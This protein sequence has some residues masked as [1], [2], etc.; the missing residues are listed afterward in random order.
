LQAQSTFHKAFTLA[1]KDGILYRSRPVSDG[2]AVSVGRVID[3]STF[4]DDFLIM[5]TDASGGAAWI[6]KC[7]TTDFEE[8]TDVTEVPDG[9]VAVGT[10]SDMT[11]YISVAVVEKFNAAGVSQWVKSYSVSGHSA[12][13]KKISTDASGNLYILGTVAIDGAGDD[14]F[15][16]K[17]DASG[18]ILAQNRFGTPDT[19]YPLAFLRSDNGSFFICG[20]DN[21]FVGENIHVMKINAD[22]TVS[23]N[24]KISGMIRYFAYDMQE[25]SNGHLV[26][27]GRYDDGADSY[28]VLLCSLDDSNGDQVWAKSFSAANG[29]GNY[30][31]GLAIKQGDVIA[32]TGPVE[33]TEQGTFLFTTDALGN[34]TWSNRYGEPGTSAMGYGVAAANDGGFLVCG[35]L[36]NNADGIVQLLKTD[37]EGHLSCNSSAYELS[38][39]A[40]TLPMQTLA[41]TTGS[42]GLAAQNHMLN[43]TAYTGL[44][45]I[46]TGT[47]LP[48]I[49]EQHVGITP[50]PS[51]GSF[52]VTAPG[53]FS[54]AQVT[55]VS[56]SGKEV[57]TGIMPTGDG[58]SAVSQGFS[59]S[60][61]AGVYFVTL[62][63]RAG[64]RSLKLVITW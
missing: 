29:A 4:D 42:P 48:L 50:N 36:G 40:L 21:T 44:T 41:I 22:M 12:G 15:I 39:T 9:L 63:N 61:P 62:G 23:W 16:L 37:S 27:A 14:Y 19:D 58:T 33:T 8:F 59:L 1:G 24:R 64:Q 18:N 56:A 55:I 11:T 32:V 31:Y 26:L 46:C 45:D 52:T 35:P 13:A 30:A 43:E 57:M 51:R 47:G 10:A 34:L 53:S 38:A 2:G 49:N 5:K 17:L 25:L 54:G 20:W 7:A 3:F 28:D 6:K 60:V